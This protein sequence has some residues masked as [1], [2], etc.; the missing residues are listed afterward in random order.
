MP[1]R[2][3]WALLGGLS[4]SEFMRDYWQ[5]K[6]LLVRGAIPAFGMSKGLE[7]PISAAELNDLAKHELVESR[8]IQSHPWR[9][10]HGPQSARGI[11]KIT[12]K[13]WT[14]LVQGMEGWHPAAAKVLSGFRFIPDYRLDDLMIS[15]AG[16]GGGVGPHLDSYDVFLI[17]MSG[18]RKWQIQSNPDKRFIED[19]PLKIL[20][21]FNPTDEWVL[22]PGDMLYLPPQV[23]HDGVALDPG[24]Q[25]WSV[26]FRA[27]SYRELIQET[28]W[29]LAD[30]LE[31]DLSLSDLLTDAGQV[32]SDRPA[33]I[34][35]PVI[36]SVKH[37]F[38]ELPWHGQ[39]LEELLEFTLGEILS[40]P[41]PTVVFSPPFEPLSEAQFRKVI[42]QEG[43]VVHPQTRLNISGDYLFCNG[44]LLTYLDKKSDAFESWLLFAHQRGF[45]PKQC[46]RFLSYASMFEPVY[47]GYLDGWFELGA[48][49]A[50]E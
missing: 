12:E 11:P 46:R 26:G 29:R 18:R 10:K 42:V 24:T 25:T 4:P 7:S 14:M 50:G 35:S 20:E 21:N 23:A 43:L 19:L 28:L 45:S 8:V 49:A 27:P 1:L 6:P 17:Q 36:Q 32:A 47:E 3:P 39:E 16:P 13:N 48:Y 30:Q 38:H 31:D 44:A 40:E 41:K 22:E 37:R 33:K 9:L 5:K 34:P 2:D 15:I